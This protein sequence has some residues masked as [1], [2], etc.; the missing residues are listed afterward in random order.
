MNKQKIMKW[1]LPALL[2]SA[3]TFELLP[4]SVNYHAKEVV[5]I[6]EAAWNFLTPP[7]QG[8]T[9][10]CLTLAVVATFAGMVLALVAACRKKHNLYTVIGW[11]SLAAGALASAPYMM[12]ST[13]EFVQPNVIILLL[14]I[15]SWLLAMYLNKKK[16]AKQ[17]D[18]TAGPRL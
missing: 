8:M 12:Q 6:P 13:E 11:C 2:M 1:A 14:L 4:G 15:V 7:T 3:M 9:A 10:S 18:S 17:E 16:D 5:Q